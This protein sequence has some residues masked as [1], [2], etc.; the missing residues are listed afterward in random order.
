[1]GFDRLIDEVFCAAV[2]LLAQIVLLKQVAATWPW[3]S[4]AE[5]LGQDRR[6]IRDPVTDQLN[7]G[8]AAHGGY[9]DQGFFHGQIAERSPLLEQVDP[10][11]LLRRSLRLRRQRIWRAATFLAGLGI[12]GFD[13]VD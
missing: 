5:P 3:A 6:L 8:K 7:A 2:D 1:M 13:Q 12:V 9:L 4:V 11:Q 10:Q